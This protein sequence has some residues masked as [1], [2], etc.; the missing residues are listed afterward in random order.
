MLCNEGGAVVTA[1]VYKQRW[2]GGLLL[3]P[4]AACAEFCRT[5][6]PTRRPGLSG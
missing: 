5:Q 4:L 1:N 6:R 3:F 2:V